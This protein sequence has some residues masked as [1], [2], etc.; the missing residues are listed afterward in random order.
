MVEWFKSNIW[1]IKKS[2]TNQL[3]GAAL[4]VG[5]I[6]TYIYWTLNNDLPLKYYSEASPMCW[7]ILE[8]C[9]GL[10]F[11]PYGVLSFL[12]YS[13]VL[14]AIVG[15]AIF[16]STRTALPGWILL[17][18]LLILKALFYFQDF[19]LSSNDHYYLFFLN[20]VYLFIPNK[21]NVLKALIISFYISSGL[22]KLSP[23]WLTGQWFNQHSVF[24]PKL[25]EWFSAL[26]VLIE[27]IAPWGLLFRDG[28][29]FAISFLTL[30]G[31]HIVI[32][33]LDG[34]Y[35][36][37]LMLMGLSLFLFSYFEQRR[38]EAEYIYQSFIRPDPSRSWI[39]IMIT[40]FWLFQMLPWIPTENI[41][42]KQGAELLALNRMASATECKQ[43]TFAIYNDRIEEIDIDNPVGRPEHLICSP[44]LRFLDSKSLCTKLK[45]MPG[46]QTISSS[47]KTR[48]LKDKEFR[49]AFE[50][51]D[52]CH[53]NVRLKEM[54]FYSWNTTTS[55]Q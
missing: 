2:S 38:L 48:D 33:Y 42:V 1:E 18:I 3:F 20:F 7:T 55:A 39:F 32:W 52:F 50:I 14:I 49:V 16:F 34:F 23:E 10:R 41:K 45:D 21:E 25:A 15:G 24:H 5:H 11:L 53:P 28:R 29:Y 40:V 9:E 26:S 4:C 12:Y 47:L 8:N 35:T 19:R 31:Y 46:F 6:L 54:D 51:L 13:Y 43:T 17:F 37:S 44:Y 30:V 27:M 22:L 36:S